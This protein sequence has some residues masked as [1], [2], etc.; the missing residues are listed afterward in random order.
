[1][2]N[3]TSTTIT[4]TLDATSTITGPGSGISAVNASNVSS[5][6]LASDRLPTVPTTKGGT[7]LTS[8]GTADQVLKVNSGG[9]ALEF[10]EAGGGLQ[11]FNIVKVTTTS[12]YTPT[13]GTTFVR[14]YATGGGGG[15]GGYGTTGNDSGVGNGGAGGNTMVKGYNA[16]ELGAT[17]AI[18]IGSGG[19]GGT[20][21]S[22]A[23]GQGGTG[24]DTNFNPAGTGQTL[25]GTGGYGSLGFIGARGGEP[26][27]D[28]QTSTGNSEYIHWGEL[29][30]SG[31]NDN[32]QVFREDNTDY[33]VS[34]AGGSSYFGHGGKAQRQS[35]STA[36][37]NGTNA[38]ANSGG[39]AGGCLA[40]DV[41][42]GAFTM[43]GGNGGSG[44]VII[45]EYA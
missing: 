11:L 16:T 13:A 30:G 21:S 31:N 38:Q 20:G 3:L 35:S 18:T 2:A 15:S 9:T 7:G 26:A 5:G 45:E 36:R 42:N 22:T 39:G 10:G 34:T 32:N 24:S 33:F 1:M 25:S 37:N 12:T 17:A 29:T 6:T 43:N 41:D 44:V 23:P 28:W 14:V 4:G 8:I 27:R 19:S 40:K